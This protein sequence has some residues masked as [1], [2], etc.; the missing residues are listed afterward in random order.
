[1]I[2]NLLLDLLHSHVKFLCRGLGPLVTVTSSRTY[3]TS[4]PLHRHRPPSLPGHPVQLFLKPKMTRILSFGNFLTLVSLPSYK[5][6]G[7]LYTWLLYRHLHHVSQS[8]T[9]NKNF[10]LG[11]PKRFL[12]VIVPNLDSMILR[13]HR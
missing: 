10:Y 1:M 11:C 6:V 9:S 4:I 3:P 5:G 7:S 13:T 8:N 12:T 2:V